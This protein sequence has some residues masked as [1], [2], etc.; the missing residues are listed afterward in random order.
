MYQ[1]GIVHTVVNVLSTA[2][3]LLDVRS[4]FLLL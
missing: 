3:L 1:F 4:T 2:F